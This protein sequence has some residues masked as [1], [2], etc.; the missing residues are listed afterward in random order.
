MT[1]PES[2]QFLKGLENYEYRAPQYR[3]RAYDPRKVRRLLK[4]AG[5]SDESIRI[6]HIAGTKGKGSTAHYLSR[7]IELSAPRERTGLFTSPHLFSL[8]ERIRVNS[9][10]ISEAEFAR[11]VARYRS[12]LRKSRATF[13]EAMTFLA[14]AHFI[15]RD[16]GFVILETG[17]GGRL[18]STNY[19]RPAL[20]AITP[21]GYDHTR[22]LGKTLG[23]IAGEKAGIIKPG[24]PVVVARQHR[25]ALRRIS[26][27][28]HGRKSRLIHVP[29]TV[30]ARVRARGFSGSVFDCTLWRNR[31]ETVWK[32]VRLRQTGDAFVDNFLMALVCLAELGLPLRSAVIRKAARIRI[33]GR[34]T[35]IPRGIADVSHNDQSLRLLFQT[36]MRYIRSRNYHLY[37]TILADKEIRRIADTV[38]EYAGLFHRI[39]VFDFPCERPSGG[40]ALYARLKKMPHVKYAADLSQ[41]RPRKGE[42]NVF[43]GSFYM[44]RPLLG[45]LK[46]PAR[47]L[48]A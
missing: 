13:F 23:R 7:L 12:F 15:A 29:D 11:L 6:I 27:E 35:R 44:F 42:F 2:V 37:L 43:A 18:D 17:M 36:L 14:M 10:P 21:V 40:K 22:S 48:R 39:T 34:M 1:Y 45:R 31:R 16:C 24:V 32:N 4:R 46:I 30:Q 19:C 41:V 3:A 5:L 38:R 28:A 25:Q 26:R 8:T 47:L 20:T 9:R 33:P